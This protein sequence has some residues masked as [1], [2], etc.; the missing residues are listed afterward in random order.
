MPRNVRVALVHVCSARCVNAVSAL[1]QW[2]ASPSRP[3]ML[4]TTLSHGHESTRTPNAPAHRTDS[5]FYPRRQQPVAG[6]RFSPRVVCVSVFL[7]DISKAK[8]ARVNKLDTEM[9]HGESWKPV[10]FGVRRSKAKVSSYKNS[11]G[12]NLCTLVSAGLFQFTCSG[13]SQHAR[14]FTSTD[15]FS[16]PD[17]S[18]VTVCV[19]VCMYVCVIRQ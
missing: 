7:H 12:V 15:F 18:V 8:A 4:S 17:R 19:C 5:P 6:V 16:G 1:C 9:F 2:D 14:C 10:Y 13:D 3:P 11:T